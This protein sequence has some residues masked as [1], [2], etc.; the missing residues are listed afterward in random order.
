MGTKTSSNEET[1][2]PIPSMQADQKSETNAI[3]LSESIIEYKKQR[4]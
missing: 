1:E 3:V 4:D 2:H